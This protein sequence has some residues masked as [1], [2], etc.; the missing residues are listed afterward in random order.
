MTLE[1]YK[2]GVTSSTEMLDAEIALMQAKLTHTQA[3]VD[4]TLALARLKK[5]VGDNL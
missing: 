2:N 4:C 5:A 1:K 3:I